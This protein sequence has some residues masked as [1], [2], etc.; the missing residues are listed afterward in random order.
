MVVSFFG[1]KFSS[2]APAYQESLAKADAL[3]SEQTV[4]VE[5]VKSLLPDEMDFDA[6]TLILRVQEK[7]GFSKDLLTEMNLDVSNLSTAKQAKHSQKIID[8]ETRLTQID[9]DIAAIETSFKENGVTEEQ[10]SRLKSLPLE[11]IAADQAAVKAKVPLERIGYKWFSLI[12][13]VIFI[14][15]IT[16][17]CV[18]IK[19]KSTVDM[20]SAS[21][22]DMFKALVQNDQAMTMVVAIVCIN[23]ALYI[24]SNLVIYFFKYDFSPANWEGNYTLFNTFGGGFQILAMMIL[25]PVFRKFM[26][27]MKIFYT[28]FFMA[29]VGYLILLVVSFTGTTSFWA[30]VPSAFLIM[31]AIGMLNVV[32]TVFLANTVDYGELKNGR[33]DEA[34]IFSMQTFVVKL[35]SGLSALIAGIILS[36]CHVNKDALVG[37]KLSAASS[38]SLRMCMTLIPIIVLVVGVLVFKAK[39]K[40]NDAKVAE[41]SKEIKAKR[42]EE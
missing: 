10:I 40:L 14:L 31:S 21:V 37:T 24:T 28:S 33:R 32:V 19:E 13:A 42:G 9:S 5:N 7:N 16:I 34:V 2:D 38:T 23:T 29:F 35:A 8:L 6:D 26:N 4:L 20:K 39:Y 17:M 30:L 3:K 41:I 22:G 36:I 25:F 1:A 11:I 18:C 27:T 12:I 15:F